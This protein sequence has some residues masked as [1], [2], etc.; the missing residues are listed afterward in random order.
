[1]PI[2]LESESSIRRKTKIHI[3]SINGRK[4]KESNNA[5]F[6]ETPAIEAD[7]FNYQNHREYGNDALT[8]YVKGIVTR[9]THGGV[10]SLG[11]S[12]SKR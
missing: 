4:I 2:Q 10:V 8:T 5:Y 1:M 11:T 3:G 12:R 6:Q 7:L 9:G